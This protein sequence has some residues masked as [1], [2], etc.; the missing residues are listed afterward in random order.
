[1]SSNPSTPSTPSTPKRPLQLN[2]TFCDHEG[3]FEKPDLLRSA[4]PPPSLSPTK[5]QIKRFHFN[6]EHPCNQSIDDSAVPFLKQI[7]EQKA[8]LKQQRLIYERKIKEY[9]LQSNTKHRSNVA[10]AMSPS[11]KRM[12][13]KNKMQEICKNKLIPRNRGRVTIPSLPLD[14]LPETD[15]GPSTYHDNRFAIGWNFLNEVTKQTLLS[16]DDNASES[17]LNRLKSFVSYSSMV[18]TFNHYSARWQNANDIRNLS[19]LTTNRYR[20]CAVDLASSVVDRQPL[21][22]NQLNNQYSSISHHRFKKSLRACY[23]ILDHRPATVR[24]TMHAIPLLLPSLNI[25]FDPSPKQQAE[26]MTKTKKAQKLQRQKHIL[27]Q[28]RKR[29]RETTLKLRRL[30]QYKKELKRWQRTRGHLEEKEERTPFVTMMSF[31]D[32]KMREN[33]MNQLSQIEMRKDRKSLISSN[34]RIEQSL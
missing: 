9:E 23:Q 15:Q 7:T 8:K 28:K 5:G 17:N 1:M 4:T 29:L 30:K 3:I 14:K 21:N 18:L 26:A 20:K 6:N 32:E 13:I 24:P 25:V 19:A 2:T 31:D 12:V 11:K 34:V 16:D 22:M 10:M 27:E 33:E